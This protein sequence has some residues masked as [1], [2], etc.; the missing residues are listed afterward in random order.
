MTTGQYLA[1]VFGWTLLHFCW[2]GTLIAL[3]LAC[4]LALLSKHS[5]Q[6]RYGVCCAALALNLVTLAITFERVA[7]N[8]GGRLRHAVVSPNGWFGGVPEDLVQVTPSRLDE[9]EQALDHSLPVVVI[10]W[11]LG[12][13][14]CV[15]RLSL[16]LAAARRLRLTGTMPASI[17]E[18]HLFLALRERIGIDRPVRLLRSAVVQVPAVVG[19]LRPV[20]LIPIGALAGLSQVQIEAIFAHELAHIRRHD[21]L[22]GILQSVAESLLFYHPAVWWISHQIRKERELCCDDLAVSWTGDPVLYAHALFQLAAQRSN[23]PAITLNANGG[24]LTMRIR[25]LLN[26]NNPP[27]VQPFAVLS[28]LALAFIVAGVCFS[29]AQAQHSLTA[30]D[31]LNMIHAI[32]G[33]HSVI[34]TASKESSDLMV[35]KVAQPAQPLLTT[36]DLSTLAVADQKE[37]EKKKPIRV[38]ASIMAGQIVSTVNPVYPEAARK[39]RIEGTV[40]LHAIISETGD[41]MALQVLSGPTALLDSAIDAVQQWKYKP[42]LLNGQPIEVSTTISVTYSISDESSAVAPCTTQNSGCTMPVLL[43]AVEPEYPSQAREAKSS[44]VVIVSLTVDEKGTPQNLAVFS[45]AGHGFDEKAL[46]A[47]R[48]YRFQPATRNGLPTVAELKITVNFQLF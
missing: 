1:H 21:Y 42:Y 44:G 3:L 39:A 22:V 37:Q 46:E 28:V 23:S 17:E 8:D 13:A 16:G 20:V 36:A 26:Q 14:L 29:S 43:S 33:V 5:P 48:R 19:W 45:S 40:V 38:S 25:R 47:V 35:A 6:L 18:T 24:S 32:T 15:T 2:Q 10:V 34:D 30:V 12:F 4:V 7:V 31:R 27:A 11:S 9:L 41:V